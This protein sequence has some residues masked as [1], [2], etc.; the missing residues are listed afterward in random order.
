MA[1]GN[2]KGRS[3]G[4]PV[5]ICQSCQSFE[6]FTFDV[7]LSKV[8]LNRP[9]ITLKNNPTRDIVPLMQFVCREEPTKLLYNALDEYLDWKENMIKKLLLSLE[10]LGNERPLLLVGSSI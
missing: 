8:K 7:N 9:S 5:G 10:H 3:H 1:L 2:Q 4:R 6:G